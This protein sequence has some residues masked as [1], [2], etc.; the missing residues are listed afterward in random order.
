MTSSV[1]RLLILVALLSI[2]PLATGQAVRSAGPSVY[3]AL[4]DSL[5]AGIGSS[6]PRERGY[7]A[8]VR[9]LL[10]RQ[11]G[12]DVTLENLAV[13]GETVASF[14]D[15]GQLVRFRSLVER[16]ARS[17]ARIVAVSLSL[18]GN[19]MLGASGGDPA[20]RQDAL[21]AFAV[22]FPAALADI[23]SI[24]GPDVPIV[25]TTYY[26]P[27]GGDPSIVESDAWWVTQF[28]AVISKTASDAHARIADV[29]TAFANRHEELTLYP[30]DVHPSNAGHRAI[31]DAVWTALGV[32]TTAP[33][34]D[35]AATV[36]ATRLTPTLRFSVTDDTG[37]VQ[38][39]ID[40]GGAPVAGPFPTTD[41]DYV[42]LLDLHGASGAVTVTIR[43]SD[44]AGNEATSDTTVTAP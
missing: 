31:A 7:P 17:D 40:S 37:V 33:T 42:A 28:N 13:P 22:A 8:L 27:A 21:D 38:V 5:A 11:R 43:A 29:A 4:G 34:I 19:E 2:G 6:L 14:R 20:G 44:A 32:D 25:V 23:R 35:V 16:L 18:G 3:I 26:D 9:D 24:F 41:G 12:G 1:V 10:A 36:S 30:Y 15:A 39:S